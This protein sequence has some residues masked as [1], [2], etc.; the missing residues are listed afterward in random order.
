MIEIEKVTQVSCLVCLSNTSHYLCCQNSSPTDLLTE[1]IYLFQDF[2]SSNIDHQY[3][4]WIIQPLSVIDICAGFG[5]VISQGIV[6]SD[7][8]V[9]VSFVPSE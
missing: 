2:Y 3:F 7:K 6:L 8:Q 9:L 4:E 1:I 5:C